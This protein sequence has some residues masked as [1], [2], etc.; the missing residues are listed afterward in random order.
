MILLL[1]CAV[2]MKEETKKVAASKKANA[3]VQA[4]KELHDKVKEDISNK[5]EEAK[6]AGGAKGAMATKLALM[7]L[8][9]RAK[10]DAGV[11]QA[12]RIFFSV[13]C[14]NK[15]QNPKPLDVWMA[16]SW[17]MGKAIDFMARQARMKNRNNVMD[18]PKLHIFKGD[19]CISKPSDRTVNEI[20]SEGTIVDGDALE[21]KLIEEINV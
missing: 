20:L 6:A 13:D 7:K 17:T 15:Q 11:P 8:K 3:A 2:E 18:A 4:A 12:D 10:G 16:K 1:R 19:I 21:F 9:G 5:L 14:P